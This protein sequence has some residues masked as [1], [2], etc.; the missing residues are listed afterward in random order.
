MIVPGEWS[1][2]S[3][4]NH[5][6]F[7]IF[8]LPY[9]GEEGSDGGL[10]AAS[11][12]EPST[13]VNSEKV[14]GNVSCPLLAQV[15]YSSSSIPCEAVRFWP[16]HLTYRVK[17]DTAIHSE[18]FGTSWNY[19][20]EFIPVHYWCKSAIM[21]WVLL[22]ELKVLEYFPASILKTLFLGQ[23]I[24]SSDFSTISVENCKFSSGDQGRAHIYTCILIYI[25][26][27]AK[28]KP[29]RWNFP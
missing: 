23:T 22:V 5:K 19:S 11:Q 17:T 27:S 28:F 12:G 13:N 8:S 29:K 24:N 25:H 6:P 7:V 18:F 16:L 4:L 10:L 9:P 20:A 15:F 21:G 3:Y 14:R 1:L 26:S 2:C